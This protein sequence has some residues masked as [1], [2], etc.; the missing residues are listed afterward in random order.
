MTERRFLPLE[1]PER[2]ILEVQDGKGG[3]MDHGFYE[4]D[5]FARLED[6][7]RACTGWGGSPLFCA[8]SAKRATS[9]TCSTVEATST[10]T[11][12]SP[13]PAAATPTRPDPG[14]PVRQS[15]PATLRRSVPHRP[16]SQRCLL[17]SE[18]AAEG[19]T[20]PRSCRGS[21]RPRA[22][23]AACARCPAH[24]RQHPGELP[25]TAGEARRHPVAAAFHCERRHGRVAGP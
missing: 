7:T 12:W 16:T 14:A 2:F 10:P 3:W 4:A 22:L 5:K 20:W 23:T 8:V 18:A 11:G 21:E 9:S 19:P 1:L 15:G 24:A 6:G 17:L 25:P 13:S